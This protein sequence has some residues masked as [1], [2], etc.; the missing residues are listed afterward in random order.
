MRGIYPTGIVASASF[1]PT[2]A[3][4]TAGDVFGVYQTFTFT[5]ANGIAINYG[6]I[7]RITSVELRIDHTA[8]VASEGAYTIHLFTA[9]PTTIADNA[10][11]TLSS[12]DLA[13][14]AGSFAVGTPV[15][16]GGALFVKTSVTTHDIPLVTDKL[17]GFLINAATIT[18]TAVA[19]QVKL[20]GSIYA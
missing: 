13:S 3:A 15:D 7:I 14:Y 6:Q 11:H 20:I 12:A 5:S 9:A 1:T 19:R 17:Y 10:A 18:P 8:L 16:A 4:Y 2:A